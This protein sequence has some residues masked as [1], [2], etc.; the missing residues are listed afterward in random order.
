MGNPELRP[1]ISI[2][3]PA[4]NE[5]GCLKEVVEEVI[6]EVSKFWNPDKCEIILIDDGSSDATR[7]RM[8]ESA[9]DWPA[10]YFRVVALRQN[11]GQTAAL[12]AGFSASAGEVV[13]A[14]DADGQ[15]DPSDI[16]RL[17]DLLAAGGYSCVSGWRKTRVHDG[18]LRVS[19]SR[20]ANKL[21][22]LASQLDINDSGCTLKAYRGNEI[23]ALTLTGDMHRLIPFEIFSRGGT[24]AEL[25]VNHRARLDGESKYG[26]SRVTK[27]LQDIVVVYLIRRF[28]FSP[29]RLLGGIATVFSVLGATGFSLSLFLKFTG[30]FDFVETPILLVSLT[31]LTAGLNLFGVGLLGEMINR[32][33]FEKDAKV[34]P[35]GTV[36]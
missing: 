24:V 20:M 16:V 27:V 17:V 28:S 35:F 25:E 11:L 7:K 33:S 10:W 29:M 36:N 1:S 6:R 3:I 26:F 15:N 18:W 8:L 2:V 19:L 22:K 23:R 5:E 4:F 34:F 12:S 13:V 14:M 31:L 32:R 9:E 30:T 21:L